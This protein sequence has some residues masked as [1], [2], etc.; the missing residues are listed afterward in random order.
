METIEAVYE[1]GV[2]RPVE[3]VQLN[4]G[5][6]VEITVKLLKKTD[7]AE[8]IPGLAIDLDISDLATNVDH[9]LYSLPKQNEK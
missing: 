4:E 7:S 6:K 5:V 3:K 1:N 9:Y 8:A 2:F